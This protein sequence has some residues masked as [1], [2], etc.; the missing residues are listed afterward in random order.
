MNHERHETDLSPNGPE[1]VEPMHHQ[2][3]YG[4]HR[5][6]F[7][8]MTVPLSS[9][10]GGF[11]T[12]MIGGWG[13]FMGPLAILFINKNK[14]KWSSVHKIG[15]EAMNFNITMAMVN[16]A[17]MVLTIVTQGRS[18]AVLAFGVFLTGSVWLVMNIRAAI[19]MARGKDYRYPM[20][21][22]FIVD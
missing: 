4:S 22:R 8:A 13:I 19:Y 6:R 14:Y 3:S 1:A 20:S 7:W 5:Q 18:G 11:L 12:L 17:L 21:W 15:I 2:S 10:I 9:I 16:W